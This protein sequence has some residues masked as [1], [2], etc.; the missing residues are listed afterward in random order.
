MLISLQVWLDILLT[1]WCLFSCWW[2]SPLILLLR[3][4]Q[5]FKSD[6]KSGYKQFNPR[7]IFAAWLTK[8]FPKVLEILNTSQNFATH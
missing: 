3:K 7:F 5:I 4:F 6:I 2:V 1:V 8:V